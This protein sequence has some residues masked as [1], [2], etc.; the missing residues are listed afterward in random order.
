MT[1]ITDEYMFEML[2]KS[3]DYTVVLLTAGPNYE[4]PDART[5]IFEHARR[6]FS[7]RA[8]GLLPIVCR[9]TDDSSWSGIGIFDGTVEEVTK[10][11]EGDPGVQAGIFT[12]EVHPVSS[13]PGDAL[14]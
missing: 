12:Y 5:T 8:E 3:R 9:V 4:S 10:I 6:N 14:P 1:E 13:F 11:V 7:L 2:A